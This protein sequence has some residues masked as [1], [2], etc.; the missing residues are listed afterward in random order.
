ML[1]FLL[2]IDSQSDVTYKDVAY[3]KH[4]ALFCILLN[5]RKYL[6]LTSLFL[7]LSGVS[8]GRYCQKMSKVEGWEKRHR[9][10]GGDSH[11]RGEL[12]VEGR[13][14][15]FNRFLK[16]FKKFLEDVVNRVTQLRN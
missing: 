3:K 13:L 4:V 16:F 11:I 14:K 12:S 8:F 7:Y 2:T 6:S 15:P 10:F 5:I 9:F 1:I